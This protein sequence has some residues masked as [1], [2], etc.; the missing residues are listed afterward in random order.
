MNYRHEYHAGSFADVMKHCVLIALMEAL[1]RK[2]AP[3]CLIDTHAG[4]GAY[5]LRSTEAQKTAEHESGVSEFAKISGLP[6]LLERYL[7]LVQ[8]DNAL[9]WPKISHYPGSPSFMARFRRAQDRLILNELHPKAFAELKL[10]FGKTQ[11]I[12]LHQRDAYEFLPAILPPAEKR[13]LVL[14]DPP[15]EKTDEFKTIFHLLEEA[16]RKCSTGTY[17]IWFPIT[18]TSYV[19]FYEKLKKS[20][21]PKILALHWIRDKAALGYARGLLGTGMI[22]VNPPWRLEDALCPLLA[23]FQSRALPTEKCETWMG[24][25]TC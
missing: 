13:G 25:L 22:I 17:A 11:G 6:P 7:A 15:Y 21:I 20:G 4:C 16:N 19:T 3:F 10:N 5:N 2:E 8:E 23:F 1:Q 14:I 24:P 9:D 18:D 12:H